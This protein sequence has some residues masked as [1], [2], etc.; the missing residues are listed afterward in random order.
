MNK[1]VK[2]LV[3]LSLLVCSMAVFAETA[4]TEYVV[5][6]VTG[7]VEREVSAGKFEAVTAGLKLA[8]STVINTGVNSTLVVKVGD[9]LVTIKAMQKGTVEK[10][11]SG[12]A[13]GN[14]GIKMG[15]KAATTD[16]T[17]EDGQT[18]KNTATASTR[19]S[20]ATEDIN[21]AEE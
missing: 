1:K 20:S 16:I 9:R 2:A 18:R 15:A 8:P 12:V 7:K 10:L 11:V 14:S 17:A 5:Q 6:S 4:P 3:G 21:W 19:A 13:A